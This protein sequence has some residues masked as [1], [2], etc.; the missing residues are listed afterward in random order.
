MFDTK[1]FLD[2][3]FKAPQEIVS[4]YR[5]YGLDAPEEQAVYKWFKRESVPSTQ[6]PIV[7][8]LIELEQGAPARLAKYIK[9]GGKQ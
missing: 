6:L 2:D 7:L 5:S 9:R 1:A 8:C 4:L 3:H